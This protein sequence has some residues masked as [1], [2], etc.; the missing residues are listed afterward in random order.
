MS[1]YR[2]IIKIFGIRAV[3]RAIETKYALIKNLHFNL[4]LGKGAYIRKNAVVNGNIELGNGTILHNYSMLLAHGGF[5][6]L[7]KNCTVNPYSILYG[8]G[9]LEIGDYVHIAAHTVI[10]P[11]NHIFKSKKKPICKQGA[12]K[13]GI[14]IKNDVWIGAHVTILDGV[15]IGEGSVIGAGSVVTKNIPK[16]SIAVGVPAKVISKR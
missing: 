6:R 5:I 8:H 4:T 16:Y 2:D 12:S 7:G 3:F 14:T 1:L 15:E 11:A 10:I 13:K 9:G